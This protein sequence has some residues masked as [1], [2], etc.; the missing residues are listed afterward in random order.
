MLGNSLAAAQLVVS[1]QGLGSVELISSIFIEQCAK[2]VL[3]L[4]LFFLAISFARS[5]NVEK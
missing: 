4:R 5:G 2:S 1:Q 3:C